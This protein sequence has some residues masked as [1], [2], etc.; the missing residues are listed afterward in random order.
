MYRYK[1]SFKFVKWHLRKWTWFLSV[2]VRWFLIVCVGYRVLRLSS[3]VNQ[4]EALSSKGT[5][6]TPSNCVY[7][8]KYSQIKSKHKSS[9]LSTSQASLKTAACTVQ[10]SPA[11]IPAITGAMC[12]QQTRSFLRIEMSDGVPLV[13]VA[14]SV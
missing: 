8:L 12:S 6:P 7:D 1:P 13:I 11:N 9:Q 4:L 3:W 2:G 10:Y 14:N 5:F